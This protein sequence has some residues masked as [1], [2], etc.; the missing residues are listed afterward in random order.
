MFNYP[1]L[2][3]VDYLLLGHITK[4]IT[5]TGYSL[6][7]TATYSALTAA[8]LGMRVG[9]VT[10]YGPDL[11]VPARPNIQVSPV[12]ADTTTTFKNIYTP[13]GRIQYVHHPAAYLELSAVPDIW[14]N[15]PIV[16]LGPIMQE[17]DPKLARAFPNSLVGLTPQGWMRK[18]NGDGL[19]HYTDWPE[20]RYVLEGAQAVVFSIEDVQGDESIV[21]EL[22]PSTRVLVVTEG[23]SGSRLY[24]NGDL[25]YFRVPPVE[26][27]DPVGA[28]DIFA[29]TFF[30]RLQQTRD[31]WEAA[32]YATQLASISVSRSGTSGIPTEEEIKAGLIT[33][34]P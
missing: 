2:E 19:V 10:S 12:P 31:P 30:T 22:I 15:A 23:S 28:G 7:G 8:A 1:A 26:E 33:I 27:I 24:W 21:E 3:P 34:L 18:A 5:P 32:R 29:A 16:H 14:R 13:S 20:A 25:R 9:I 17:V 6:G 11:E 4:D